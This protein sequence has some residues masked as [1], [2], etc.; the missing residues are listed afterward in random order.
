[1]KGYVYLMTNESANYKIGFTTYPVEKRLK[2]LNRST[3]LSH[4][5]EISGYAFVENC[6]ALE[7]E[8]HKRYKY[9]RLK[10][11]WFAL[12]KDDV[13][14]IHGTFLDRAVL[15]DFKA[16]LSAAAKARDVENKIMADQ[17]VKF[18]TM[19][20]EA[21][22][23]AVIREKWLGIAWGVGISLGVYLLIFAITMSA[24]ISVNIMMIIFLLICF[25]FITYFVFKETQLKK[26]WVEMGGVVKDDHLQA[27]GY[28]IKA[29]A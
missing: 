29:K 13:M 25:N 20:N 21:E 26:V 24:T 18:N 3:S 5:I 15:G 19:L 10:G 22:T 11:E 9:K 27:H 7:K 4:T 6:V 23:K 12:D 28:T 16:P 8:L 17:L 1:M 14:T 2:E